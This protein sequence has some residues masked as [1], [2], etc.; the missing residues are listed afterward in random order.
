MFRCHPQWA[1]I[2][3]GQLNAQRTLTRSSR[4]GWVLQEPKTAKS[5]RMVT[6]IRTA[7]AALTAHRVAQ[8]EVRLCAGPARNAHDLVFGNT[9]GDPLDFK[10]L[11]RRHFLPIRKASEVPEIRPYDLRHTCATLMLASG[12]NPKVVSEQ[13]GHAR[14]AFTLDTYAHVLPTMQHDAAQRLE[15][16]LFG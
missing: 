9:L 3:N 5:R 13:L 7:L 11:A 10:L 15:E 1:D 16:A 4:G 2:Q 6:L 8:N 14:V 12:T